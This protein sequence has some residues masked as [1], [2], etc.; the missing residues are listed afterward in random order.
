[1]KL[2]LLMTGRH[3]RNTY[4]RN[5]LSRTAIPLAATAGTAGLII[6]PASATLMDVPIPSTI[7]GPLDIPGLTYEAGPVIR[8][9][10]TVDGLTLTLEV[11]QQ[12]SGAMQSVDPLSREGLL[13]TH[14]IAKIDGL[15]DRTDVSATLTTGYTFGYPI[16]LAPNRVS[17]SV[18]APQLTVSGGVNATLNP[19]ITVSQS[20][21]GGSVGS[22]GAEAGAQ[23]DVIPE[24]TATF[25][26]GAGGTRDL[27][28]A[29]AWLTSPVAELYLRGTHAAVSKAVGDVVIRP[30]AML[31]VTTANGVYDLPMYGT[32]TTL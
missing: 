16:Q 10:T 13:N 9:I 4:T 28:V 1:M 21:G 31:T 24:T 5:R 8:Y 3:H 32:N 18:T 14:L 25:D 27:T 23:A 20:G 26:V 6:S 19:H 30:Y 17:V 29:E 15:G 12:G 7:E 22:I 2:I 11:H